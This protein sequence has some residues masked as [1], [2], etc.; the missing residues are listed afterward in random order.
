MI[1]GDRVLGLIPARGGSKGLARKNLHPIGGKPLIAWTIEAARQS[2][3][4]DRIVVSTDD[5]EILKIARDYDCDPEFVRPAELA[6]CEARAVDVALHALNELPGY[7]ILVL[8]QPTSPLRTSQDVD[9]AIEQM[10]EQHADSCVSVVKP[11][12][13]PYWFYQINAEGYLQPLLGDS[14]ATSRRQELPEVRMLNGAI[15]IARVDWLM[16][17]KCFIDNET[18]AYE[19]TKERSVD[20]DD[21]Y[22]LK[23]A[24]LY[25]QEFK[26]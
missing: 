10:L 21:I 20:I 6:T 5:S 18:L 24:E 23:I 9:A 22:D 2:R 13:S 19:M 1:A 17:K 16:H 7:D 8:L 4:I 26:V 12:K 14:Y 11:D 15:Y 25:M 3:Y